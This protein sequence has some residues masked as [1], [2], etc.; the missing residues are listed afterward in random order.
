MWNLRL[1]FDVHGNQRSTRLSIYDHCIKVILLIKL[2]LLVIG[3]HI[4]AICD[5]MKRRNCDMYTFDIL[6]VLKYF[7]NNTFLAFRCLNTNL[8]IIQIISIIFMIFVW[9]I[10]WSN[11]NFDEIQK[12]RNLE[13]FHYDSYN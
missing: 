1:T 3:N 4:F 7:L 5:K 2:F 13:H 8:S 6:E 12:I 10:K 11:W 9:F